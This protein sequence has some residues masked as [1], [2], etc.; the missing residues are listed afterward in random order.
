M[1]TPS[2][3]IK[4]AYEDSLKN[5][6][7]RQ[8]IAARR[9]LA[10]HAWLKKEGPVK[11]SARRVIAKGY[12][13]GGA[14]IKSRAVHSF[15]T[16]ILKINLGLIGELDR[17]RVTNERIYLTADQVRALVENT[18]ILRDRALIVF[19]YQ[20]LMDSDTITRLKAGEVL[21]HLDEEPP[22]KI[23]SYREKV[24]V[25]YVTYIGPDAVRYLKDYIADLKSKGITL[26]DS[27]PLFITERKQDNEIA[28][29]ETTTMQAAIK[30][31]ALKSGLIE[32]GSKWNSAGFHALRRVQA[33]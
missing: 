21:P 28:G 25:N 5:P 1:L 29:I 31:A 22:V 13:D 20:S 3:L 27:D 30:A 19:A 6:L 7:E 18:K 2:E 8:D 16:K 15:Y 17:G 12:S 4:E 23:K 33:G 32:E 24:H 14:S 26:K 9:L 10:Y 11:D